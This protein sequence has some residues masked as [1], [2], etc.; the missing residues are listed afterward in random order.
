ME[1]SNMGIYGA[2]ATAITGLQA[3]STALEHISGNITNSQTTGFKRTETNFVDLVPDAP[4][5][6]QTAGAVTSFSRSTNDIQGDLINADSETSLAV[7]GRGYFVVARTTGQSDGL[8]VFEGT[9]Y[10]T[11]RGDFEIDRSGYMVNGAGNY[12]QGPFS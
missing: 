8:P 11:R 12:L 10:Y 2:L 7:N 5:R 3:Q 4:P 1:D 6:R 9:N